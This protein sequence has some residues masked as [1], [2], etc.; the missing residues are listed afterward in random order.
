MIDEL[1]APLLPLAALLYLLT[2][3]ST[4]RT[5]V[6]RFPF[7]WTLF[8]EAI[9]L[10][11]LSCREPWGVI[12]LLAPASGAALFRVAGTRSFDASLCHPHGIVPRDCWL[13]AGR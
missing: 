1:S 2:V 7:T 5:K 10:A 8:S 4:L 11:T 6:R 12:V 13:A 9:L 3:V